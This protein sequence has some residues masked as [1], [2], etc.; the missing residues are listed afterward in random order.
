MAKAAER[1][2]QDKETIKAARNCAQRGL[3]NDKH[4]RDSYI[5]DTKFAKLGEQWPSKIVTEREEAGRPCLTINKMPA[6]LRQVQNDA[7]QN[8][9][10]LRVI[11]ADSQA[12][13][14]TARIMS[15]IIRNIENVSNAD[16]AYITAL[17]CSTT[18]GFGYIKID[19]DYPHHASFEIEPMINEV[20][21]P[22]TIIGD[23]DV[24]ESDSSNWMKALVM[25]QMGRDDFKRKYKGK[26][27]IGFDDN[28]WAGL[29]D[30]WLDDENIRIVEY[31]V[32]EQIKEEAYLVKNANTGV[33]SFFSKEMM[34]KP[35]V[36]AM[37]E[38][39]ILTVESAKEITKHKVTQYIMSGVEILEKH[40]WPGQYIPIVPVYGE[41][42]EIDGKRYLR[43]LVHNA[44]DAQRNF[45]YWRTASTELVALAP[46]VPWVGPEGTFI[47][48]GWAEANTGNPPYLEYD[49]EVGPPQRQPL[50]TGAAAGALTEAANA[51]DDIKATTG[52]FDASMG[53]RS[54]ETSGKAILARQREGD[55]STFHFIDNLTRA[56]QHVGVILVDLIPHV[57]SAERMVRILG[58]DE[59]P[60]IVQVNKEMPRTNDKGEPET[61]EKGNPLMQIYD[62]R[63]GKYDVIAKAGPAFTTKREEA[64]TQMMELL[65]VYPASAPF[66]ADLLAKNLDWPG[67]DEIADRLKKFGPMAQNESEIP[68]E[69]QEKMAEFAE[70]MEK[71]KAENEE[72]SKKLA[73]KS[74]QNIIDLFEAKTE[75]MEV[76][77]KNNI[78]PAALMGME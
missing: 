70:A 18:G 50:D 21:N 54:N 33:T 52:L 44:K 49:P 59:E 69:I 43:G 45:N 11:P 6:V 46:K 66:V 4:N 7:R 40:D 78:S 62:L 32:R 73:D 1:P 13:K 25:E 3:D 38:S 22:L 74:A 9:P 63:V 57:Y 76:A 37:V 77:L 67:A 68:P 28:Q 14:D 35:E 71:L 20:R 23:P 5:V 58:E 27:Q 26:S 65:R 48:D 42:F 29:D 10:S 56:L 55:V 72:M 41:D 39:N 64:A 17:D 60:E 31:W 75:R 19:L 51:S 12:D 47:G 2:N 15:G 30:G 8:K 24:K 16:V 34:D 61:D 36:R 53:A